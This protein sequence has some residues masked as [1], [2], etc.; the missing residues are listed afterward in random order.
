[1]DLWGRATHAN[2]HESDS[3][4]RRKLDSWAVMDFKRIESCYVQVFIGCLELG[5]KGIS[6]FNSVVIDWRVV[7]L[8]A[9]RT[10]GYEG[11]SGKIQLYPL[12]IIFRTDVLGNSL[13]L[14]ASVMLTCQ[15]CDS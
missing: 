11:H 8:C 1:M 15:H 5:D 10:R 2:D 14:S 9:P 13:G 6:E 3:R 12:L 7:Y 4:V